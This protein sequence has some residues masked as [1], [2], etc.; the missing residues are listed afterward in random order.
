M[1]GGRALAV[2]SWLKLVEV[3]LIVGFG[4]GVMSVRGVM[5]AFVVLDALVA[6]DVPI[7]ARYVIILLIEVKT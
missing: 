1:V 7:L 5:D 6:S 3:H 2:M 4:V